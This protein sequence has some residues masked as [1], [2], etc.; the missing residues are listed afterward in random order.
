MTEN[1]IVAIREDRHIGSA[2]FSMIFH[3]PASSIRSA[4]IQRAKRRASVRSITTTI[5]V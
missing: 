4:L 2:T 5:I 3:S 1:I